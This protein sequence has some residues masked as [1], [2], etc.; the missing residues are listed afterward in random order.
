MIPGEYILADG[1]ITGNGGRETKTT[2]I[3]N[4]GDRPVQIGSHF[5]FAEVNPS[6]RFDRAEAYGFRLDI[7]AGTAVRLE[8]GDSRSVNLV[9]IGGDRVVSGFRDLVDGPLENRKNDVWQGREDSWR[10]SSAA[11]DAPKELPQDIAAKRGR[12]LDEGTNGDQEK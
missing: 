7:P 4:T 2:E 5:H 1:D 6:I 10:R 11:G 8:P 9:A 12:K 3:V